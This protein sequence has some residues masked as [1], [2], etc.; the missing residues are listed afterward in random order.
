V[1]SVVAAGQYGA[2]PR[3]TDDGAIRLRTADSAELFVLKVQLPLQ[4]LPPAGSA[5]CDEYHVM[6]TEAETIPIEVELTMEQ[7]ERAVCL[8]LDESSYRPPSS[9]VFGSFSRVK[10]AIRFHSERGVATAVFTGPFLLVQV[11]DDL[12]QRMWGGV[13][14]PSGQE[15]GVLFGELLQKYSP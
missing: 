13:I 12:D 10:Y 6:D 7:I 1:A 14:T 3:I 11:N 8:L 9:D 5:E 2:F 15:W 4:T